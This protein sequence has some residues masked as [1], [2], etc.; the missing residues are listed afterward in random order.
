[1]ILVLPRNFARASVLKLMI[2]KMFFSILET[3]DS[4]H[5]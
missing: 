5:S 3:Q 4:Q 2:I 1:M